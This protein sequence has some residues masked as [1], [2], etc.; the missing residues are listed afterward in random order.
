MYITRRTS[1]VIAIVL[2]GGFFTLAITLSRGDKRVAFRPSSVESSSP[3]TQG[4]SSSP[5]VS[6]TSQIETGETAPSQ[7][8]VNSAETATASLSSAVEQFDASF[9]LK[10][11]RRFEA[12]DGKTVWEV[13]AKEGR[14]SP[15]KNAAIVSDVDLTMYQKD[16]TKVGLTAREA[17]IFLDGA[18]LDRAEFKGDVVLTHSSGTVIRTDAATLEHAKAEVHAPGRVVITGELFDIEGDQ[19]DGKID[20]R[21]FTLARNVSTIIRPRAEIEA[22]K[23]ANELNAARNKSKNDE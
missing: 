4:E 17:E 2:I 15:E 20:S 13:A 10:T 7:Q 16:N 11:F 9:M 3:S 19:L 1:I 8:S 18:S 21:E 22:S 6:E 5:S 14:F 23:R 12:R